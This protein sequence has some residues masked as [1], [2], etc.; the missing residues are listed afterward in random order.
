MSK[1]ECFYDKV[2]SRSVGA[3]VFIFSLLL[4]IVGTIVLPVFG[5]FFALPL[6]IMAG[7]F[8]FAPDSKACRLL[9]AKKE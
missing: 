6:I 7:F 3:V 8:V 2:S 4:A 1:T 9:S 5:F